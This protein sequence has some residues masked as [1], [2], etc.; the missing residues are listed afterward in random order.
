MEDFSTPVFYNV[1]MD[2]KLEGI[3]AGLVILNHA[4]NFNFVMQSD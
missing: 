4:C 3:G 1:S 2:S